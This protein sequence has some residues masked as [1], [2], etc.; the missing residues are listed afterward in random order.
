MHAKLEPLVM[1]IQKAVKLGFEADPNVPIQIAPCRDAFER[2]RAQL[3][4]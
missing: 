3:G 2:I 1:F 4:D